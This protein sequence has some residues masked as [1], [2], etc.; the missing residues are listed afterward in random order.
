MAPLTE[1]LEWL[2]PEGRSRR[3]CL[4]QGRGRDCFVGTELQFRKMRRSEH[5]V[6]TGYNKADV[7]KC[8]WI[9]YLKW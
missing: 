9:V 2:D 7:P 3:G 4:G 8:H 6:G 5:H 1:V